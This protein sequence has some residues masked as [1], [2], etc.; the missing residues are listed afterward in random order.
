MEQSL[1][2]DDKVNNCAGY[3]MSFAL[4]ESKATEHPRTQNGEN[5][6]GDMRNHSRVNNSCLGVLGLHYYA[7]KMARVIEFLGAQKQEE[8][9]VHQADDH[10]VFTLSGAILVLVPRATAVLVILTLAFLDVLASFFL[11]ILSYLNH[12]IG[13]FFRFVCCLFL[14]RCLLFSHSLG[15]SKWFPHSH[16]YSYKNKN[17]PT[18]N[19]TFTIQNLYK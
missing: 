5:V 10:H 9:D 7:L 1:I 13:F 15:T 18:K 12:F 14:C 16:L 3:K 4:G 17:G 11:C 8:Q 6:D 19:L 2:S